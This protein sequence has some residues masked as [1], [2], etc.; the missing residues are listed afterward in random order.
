MGRDIS[1]KDVSGMIRDRMRGKH[2]LYEGGEEG[3]RSQLRDALSV[4]NEALRSTSFI[5]IEV[6]VSL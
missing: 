1:D 4:L 6:Y 3:D 2:F 5:S